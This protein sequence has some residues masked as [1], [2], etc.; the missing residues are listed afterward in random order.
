MTF[1]CFSL[2]LEMDQQSLQDVEVD[3]YEDADNKYSLDAHKRKNQSV[4]ILK[5]ISFGQYGYTIDL[6]RYKSV[7]FFFDLVDCGEQ[8]VD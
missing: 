3:K 1:L 8:V 2:H 4:L 6:C 5:V 7:V